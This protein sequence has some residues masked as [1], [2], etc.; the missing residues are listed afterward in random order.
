[1]DINIWHAR[2]DSFGPGT[3]FENRAIYE[4]CAMFGVRKSKSLP[5]YPPGNGVVERL[6]WTIKDMLYST[7]KATGKLDRCITNSGDGSAMHRA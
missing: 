7:M 5:Y 2:S 6:F 1:M 4:M 3:E